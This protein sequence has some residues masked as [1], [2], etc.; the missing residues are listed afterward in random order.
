M[1]LLHLLNPLYDL[2]PVAFYG[3]MTFISILKSVKMT[4]SPWLLQVDP[5]P[6]ITTICMMCSQQVEGIKAVVCGCVRVCACV[7]ARVC[8]CM[9]AEQVLVKRD[10]LGFL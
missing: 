2:V 7:C 3:Y 10:T 1:F 4:F 5:L 8:V 6:N 9:G